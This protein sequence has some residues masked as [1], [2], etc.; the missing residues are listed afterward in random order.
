MKFLVPVDGSPASLRAVDLAVTLAKE[1][2]PGSI[3]LLNVQNQAML[4]LAEGSGLMA[5]AWLEEEEDRQ[6]EE[7]LK[8]AV[9]ACAAAGVPF[10]VRN[11]RGVPA[12]M[13]DRIARDEKIDHVVM[14][15]RGLGSI[16]GL[17]AGSVATEVLHLIAVPVTLVK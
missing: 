7:A 14:G 4:N 11:E 13:I 8:G 15:T 12:E 1:R 9:T 3:T 17:L 16:R 6:G 10:N 2:Q 5:A